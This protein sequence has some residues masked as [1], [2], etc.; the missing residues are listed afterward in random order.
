[1]H[2]T[3]SLLFY[4]EGRFSKSI[5]KIPLYAKNYQSAKIAYIGFTDYYRAFK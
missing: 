3:T 1:M 5:L 4:K 2:V